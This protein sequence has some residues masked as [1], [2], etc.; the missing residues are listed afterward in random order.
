MNGYENKFSL[1][2][3]THTHAKHKTLQFQ[4]QV[5]STVKNV[6]STVLENIWIPVPTLLLT[7]LATLSKATE[8]M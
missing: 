6:K 4:H 7:S 3:H 8:P 1:K 2:K 5:K